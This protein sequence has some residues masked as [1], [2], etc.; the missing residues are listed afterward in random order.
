MVAD[1]RK[2]ERA[3]P[4]EPLCARLGVV[5][6]LDTSPL[7]RCDE[8]SLN[9]RQLRR[10]ALDE[11]LED[12]PAVGRARVDPCGRLG[13]GKQLAGRG[14]PGGLARVQN[15]AFLRVET[16]ERAEPFGSHAGDEAALCRLS[17]L[18]R[19]DRLLEQHA[20]RDARCRIDQLAATLRTA[21]VTRAPEPLGSSA[22][23][24]DP[25]G[26]LGL[27]GA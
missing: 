1:E 14:C 10:R 15:P 7:R 8:S 12:A 17:D 13:V 20:Q 26:V 25:R 11:P 24:S 22:K 16:I 19:S 6:D 27:Y 9:A 4:C 18:E 21:A 5:L 3:Q 2:R 23:D